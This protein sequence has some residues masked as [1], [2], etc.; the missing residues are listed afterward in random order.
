MKI[1]AAASSIH[2]ALA[3]LVLPCLSALVALSSASHTATAAPASL[4]ATRRPNVILIMTDDQGYGDIGRHGNTMIRTPRLDRFHDESVRLT[5]FHVDPTCSPTR[6]ALMTGRYSTRTGVW[7]TVMG[8]SLM[9]RDEVTLADAF[10]A[11]GY[12]TGIFG[13]WHLGDT[14]PLRPQD[15]G[16][17]ETVI[18]GGGG[19]GQTPDYWG[20]DY[21]DDRYRVNGEWKPFAGYCTDVFFGEA[22]K[23][24]ERQREQP[25]FVYLPTNAPHSP[26]NIP[27]RY[28]RPYLERGVPPAMAAFYGMIEN[29]D[30]N[31][32][33]LLDRLKAL[34]LEDNTILIFMTDNGTAAGVARPADSTTAKWTG[35]NAGMRAAK[36]SE[37]D[38]GHRVPF[39]IRWP[40]RGIGGDNARDIAPL[41]A[42]FDVLPTLVD[43]AG[44]KFTPK[45]PL[46]GRSLA[47]LLEGKPVEWPARTLFV[48]VQRDE[49]PPK[50]KRSAVLTDRWRYVNGAELYDINADPGQQRDVATQHPDAVAQLRSA[51]EDWWR[52]LAPALQRIEPIL[53]G[54][55]GHTRAGLTCMDWHAPLPQIPWD[56]PQIKKAPQANGWWQIETARAGRYEFTLRQQPSATRFPLHATTARVKVGDRE[57]VAAVPPGATSI[58]I[59]LDLPAGEARLQTWLAHASSGESR[60][61]FFVDVKRVE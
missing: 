58:A 4:A 28:R 2:H 29:I 61:A 59:T 15:R 39:F 30:E 40:A 48:H 60:G 11:S 12:R 10:A 49:I 16:F 17:H 23:F 38:G 8:R 5:N 44:L 26:Y 57:A 6:S 1:L 52:S 35:F 56:Q 9:Y 24:I 14:H 19:V 51:Y 33:R 41:A 43:L 42:H 34:G 54:S 3:R 22:L 55:R 20:N 21:T 47:P 27:E 45:N 32:G 31:L 53:L 18:H 50:W 46:D 13:K 36:G 7:H 25:F 37:Y